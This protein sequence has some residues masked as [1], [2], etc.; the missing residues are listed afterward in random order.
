MSAAKKSFKDVNPALA[1]ISAHDTLDTQ[2]VQEA[3]NTHD[4]QDVQHT[5][6]TQGTQGKRGQK[7]PRVNM[8]FSV[9]NL[10]YLQLIARVEGV[11]M[12]E[13]VNRLVAADSEVRA[14]DIKAAKQL[15][16]GGK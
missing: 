6:H 12:T 11:S 4:T 8:A 5:Q 10:E 2:D 1:F 15:L 9:A 3:P 13:Y 16:K 7:L 14:A